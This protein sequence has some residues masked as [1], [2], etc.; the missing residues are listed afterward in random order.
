M[1]SHVAARSV[2]KGH[3]LKNKAGLFRPPE[4]KFS[5]VEYS[6]VLYAAVKRAGGIAMV[7]FLLRLIQI[8]HAAIKTT[9][10]FLLSPLILQTKTT[11]RRLLLSCLAACLAT[12][13][14]DAFTIQRPGRSL[15]STSRLSTASLENGGKENA[16]AAGSKITTME[17]SL[18]SPTTS[19]VDQLKAPLMQDVRDELIQK[20]MAQGVLQET[21]EQEVDL[22]L[23]DTERSQQY[24]EMRMYAQ[25]QA[26]DL[27]VEFGLQLLGAFVLGFLGLAALQQ[28]GL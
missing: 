15:V 23:E 20:Y 27:G 16:A 13:T 14:I 9:P 12:T 25:L 2:N 8:I 3:H 21:A 28:L 22:F 26:D 18:A 24:L 17:V 7:H 10:A 19:W 6:T 1:I 5:T 4:L 11:M